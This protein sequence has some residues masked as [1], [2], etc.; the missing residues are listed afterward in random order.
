MSS[1]LAM[2]YTTDSAMT[3]LLS[4]CDISLLCAPQKCAKIKKV[5]VVIVK[6]TTCYARF[7]ELGEGVIVLDKHYIPTVLT[8]IA[9]H[10]IANR[11]ITRTMWKKDHK[12]HP[13]TFGKDDMNGTSIGIGT[14]HTNDRPFVICFLFAR[15][16]ATNALEPLLELASDHPG[17]V[18][19]RTD[20]G[21]SMS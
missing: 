14:A 10:L 7:H 12:R 3:L 17:S 4:L 5:T 8:I 13:A 2:F 18:R 6:E 20:G 21:D 11:S 16:F 9:P 19:S 15:K 1:S